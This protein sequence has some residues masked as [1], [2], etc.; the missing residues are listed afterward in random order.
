L[1]FD[2]AIDYVVERAGDINVYDIKQDGDYE[3]LLQPY[4]RDQA[5]G[6]GIYQFNPEIIYDSQSDDVY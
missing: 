2:A 3:E 4:F 5:I 1:D 6:A